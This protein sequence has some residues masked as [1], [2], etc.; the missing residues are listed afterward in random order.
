M[1]YARGMQGATLPGKTVCISCGYHL[2]GLKNAD[3][4]PECGTP[5]AQSDFQDNLYDAGYPYI[6]R[7]A[8]GSRLVL[9]GQY[10][11]LFGIFA[12]LLAAWMLIPAL[13]APNWFSLSIPNESGRIAMAAGSSLWVVGWFIAMPPDTS[14]SAEKG[15][16]TTRMI[17][18]TTIVAAFIIHTLGFVFDHPLAIF[19]A[20][21]IMTG[22]TFITY[23]VTLAWMKRNAIRVGD[24]EF[25]KSIPFSKTAGVLALLLFLIAYIC[26]IV[27]ILT[28]QELLQRQPVEDSTIYIILAGL[29]F[30]L[31]V[32]AGITGYFP[33]VHSFAKAMTQARQRAEPLQYT[34]TQP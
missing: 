23:F 25:I 34:G 20:V 28:P 31:G 9:Y 29:L 8:I 11:Y 17:F 24:Q 14:A 30:A 7:L 32:L 4:C 10:V 19:F 26:F 27:A 2:A 18:R 21:F 33:M 3:L 5:C 22:A 13:G 15:Q 12:R 16:R 1:S 6:T